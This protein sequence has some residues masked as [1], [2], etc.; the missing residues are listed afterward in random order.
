MVFCMARL[1]GLAPYTGSYPFSAMRFLASFESTR[2]IWRSCRAFFETGDLNLHNLSDLFGAE[3][4][5]E[6][7]F[8]DP[9]QKFGLECP[10][11]AFL[12]PRLS[13]FSA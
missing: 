10:A 12:H 13:R 1:R 7:N 4:V 3:V 6:D 9:V 11:K 5:K 2:V 8:I